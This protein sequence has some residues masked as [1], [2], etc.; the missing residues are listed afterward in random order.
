MKLHIG[1]KYTRKPMPSASGH[2]PTPLKKKKMQNKQDDIN[3][4]RK[5][6]GHSS[7]SAGQIAG[8][9]PEGP[10]NRMAANYVYN[11]TKGTTIVCPS[12]GAINFLIGCKLG[13]TMALPR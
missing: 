6:I 11:L 4:I 12:S 13:G 2:P 1:T 7:Q 10:G 3:H 9:F 5:G 8:R